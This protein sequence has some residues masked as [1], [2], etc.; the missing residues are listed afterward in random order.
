MAIL[1]SPSELRS[2]PALWQASALLLYGLWTLRCVIQKCPSQ[3]RFAINRA[4]METPWT[5]ACGVLLSSAFVAIG[6]LSFLCHHEGSGGR[7]GGGVSD[8]S[9]QLPGKPHHKVS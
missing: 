5:L 1:I 4:L 7:L 8:L 9:S 3:P 2:F 6:I